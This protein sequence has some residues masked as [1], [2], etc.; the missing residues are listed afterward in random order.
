MS[1]FESKVKKEE[2]LRMQEM[3]RKALLEQQSKI[4]EQMER[5]RMID[6]QETLKYFEQYKNDEDVLRLVKNVLR[7]DGAFYNPLQWISKVIHDKKNETNKHQAYMQYN[8]EKMVFIG[9][10]GLSRECVVMYNNCGISRI[11]SHIKQKAL[12]MVFLE[13]FKQKIFEEAALNGI[14][15]VS[16]DYVF[17]KVYNYLKPYHDYPSVGIADTEYINNLNMENAER[18]RAIEYE[19]LQ[20]EKARKKGIT[21]TPS[22]KSAINANILDGAMITVTMPSRRLREL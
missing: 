7:G 2:R 10:D 19:K 22:A 21:G 14:N 1:I 6:Q 5:Q 4:L 20:L 15:D 16:V 8:N 3:Q 11:E 13:L 9:G 17:D 18:K 12:V